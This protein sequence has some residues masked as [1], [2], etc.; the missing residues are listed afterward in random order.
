[1]Y[2]SKGSKEFHRLGLDTEACVGKFI[3][4]EERLTEGKNANLYGKH[5]IG[6][7]GSLRNCPHIV[8][9][10]IAVGCVDWQR[11]P[12]TYIYGLFKF[13]IYFIGTSVRACIIGPCM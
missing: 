12:Y 9:R 1:M 2:T 10:N 7:L 13:G 11:F 5:Q 8:E 6:T 3:L 4:F